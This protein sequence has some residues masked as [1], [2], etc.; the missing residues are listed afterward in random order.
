MNIEEI[1][2]FCLSLEGVEEKMPFG[3]FARR[4]DSILVFYVCGHMFCMVDLDEPNY[5]DVRSTLQEI[6]KFKQNKISVDN[7]KNPAMK[8]W[9]EINFGG[10][11]HDTQILQL[12][13]RGYNII[14]EK[15]INTF[16][17]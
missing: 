3:K 15:Y 1:R 9:L 10:D 12:I 13:E 6:E 4:Y 11:I 16:N 14:R 8:F 2:D 7:P 5:V 17:R